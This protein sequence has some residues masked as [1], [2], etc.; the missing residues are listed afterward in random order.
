MST[1]TA[2][3]AVTAAQGSPF[4]SF[5]F[6]GSTAASAPEGGVAFTRGVPDAEL[7]FLDTG[8]FALERPKLHERS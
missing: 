2:R 6:C 5:N 7:H 1:S 8:H 4:G 3:G